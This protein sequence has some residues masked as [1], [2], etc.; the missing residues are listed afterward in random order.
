MRTKLFAAAVAATG[1][2]Y[3][4]AQQPV[5]TTPAQPQTQPL[6]TVPQQQD[7]NQPNQQQPQGQEQT[8]R[9]KSV[10]GARVSVQNN[11]SVGTIDDM[12]FDQDGQIE[13]VIV[14][15]QGKLVTVPWQAVKFAVAAQ[16]NVPATA[17][18][19]ITPEQFRVIPTYSVTTYPSFYTPTYRT[20][21]YRYYGLTPRDRRM[22][23]R[24]IR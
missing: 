1:L 22:I 6:G 13:Y 19:A 5:P 8:F 9:A 24:R 3:A 14:A 2:G 11:T 12:V 7:P 21:V 10:L 15:D 18:I 23:E 4:V 16:P 17:T 20:Q